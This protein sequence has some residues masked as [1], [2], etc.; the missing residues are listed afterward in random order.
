VIYRKLKTES[1][2]KKHHIQPESHEKATELFNM[3]R[4]CYPSLDWKLLSVVEPKDQE[5]KTDS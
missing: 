3:L 1:E 5:S 4:S 2:W